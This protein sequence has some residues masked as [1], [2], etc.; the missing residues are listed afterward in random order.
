MRY[1]V[2][3][4]P[5]LAGLLAVGTL[6]AALHGSGGPA[7]PE[8][9]RLARQHCATCHLPPE[10]ADLPREAWPPVLAWMSNYLGYPRTQGFLA[11]LVDPSRVPDRPAVTREQLKAI[12]EYYLAAAPAHDV[13][14]PVE[15]PHL[16]RL[17]GFEAVDSLD[18]PP[19][20]FVTLL[21]AD[22]RWGG[23]YAGLGRSRELRFLD[24]GGRALYAAVF[25]S[26]P[27]HLEPRGDGFRLSLLGDFDKDRGRAQVVDVVREDGAL[28][29]RPV[30]EDFHRLV[31]AKT[32][33]LD[34]D[35]VEDLLL[36]GFGD[37]GAGRVSVLWGGREE[38]ILV[39][40]S[41]AVAFEP[42]DFDGDGRLD[43][44]ILLAQGRQQ[45]LVLR[46]LPGRGFETR[47]IE[48][49]RPS[50]GYTH[51]LAADMDGDGR[52]DLVTVN[53]NNMELPEPPVRPYHGVRVLR[54]EGGLRFTERFFHPMPGAV[55]AVA[56]DLDAD[57]DLDLAAVSLFPDWR[58]GHPRTFV[59]LENRGDFAFEARG[60]GPEHGG[61]WM[62][63]DAGDVD[64]DGR[65]DLA[66]GAGN[67]PAGLPPSLREAVV[68]AERGRPSVLL[69]LNRR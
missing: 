32:A 17:A 29:V 30:V 16:P 4:R 47:L 42:R 5:L 11:A 39:D 3:S 21:K 7:E 20:E 65:P 60:L 67:I 25:P 50:F 1:S 48:E 44:A 18:V 24:R 35:G 57:G 23:L 61:R 52:P 46:G 12:V 36:C 37:Y 64:G 31:Q 62:S 13:L 28:R 15:G 27:V 8:G 69:L 49:K 53:G 56:A 59:L 66:L 33:D 54:N 9:R 2:R 34:G 68:D 14:V 40:R 10:P 55:R 41:G 63:I 38:E 26:E 6:G 58:S 45:L 51:L 22:P 43:V 19:G